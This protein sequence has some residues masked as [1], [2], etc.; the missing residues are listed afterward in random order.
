MRPQVSAVTAKGTEHPYAERRGAL[1]KLGRNLTAGEAAALL[2]FL[3]RPPAEDAL[4]ANL[5]NALR[6]DVANLIVSQQE[7]P[8]DAV[9][10]FVT[11]FHDAKQDATWRDYCIQFLGV[12]Y[13]RAGE[14][15]REAM[16]AVFAE[17]MKEQA[18]TM[19]GTVLLA[20]ARNAGAPGLPRDQVSATA[21]KVAA[22]RT[23][24]AA[25]RTSALQ[26]CAQLGETAALPTARALTAD[27]KAPVPLRMSAIACV[28]ALGTRADLGLLAGL[29]GVADARL[30]TAAVRAGAF[31]ESR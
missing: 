15:D 3:A 17:G 26:V 19:A 11:M 1:E 29:A 21:A 20:M 8:A 25:A 2:D 23:S 5:L 9:S 6:N 24:S 12:L 4:P 13:G 31:L 7:L 22:D 16:R 14:E 10:R 30:R 18:T 28:G 27:E